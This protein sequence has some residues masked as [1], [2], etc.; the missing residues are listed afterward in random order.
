[1]SSEEKKQLVRSFFEEVWNKANYDYLDEIYTPDFVLHALWQNLSRGGAGEASGTEAAKAV[2]AGWKEGFPDLH[3]TIEEQLC[4]G[5][6]VVTRH[7]SHATHD[8]D[9]RG[10]PAT[11][12]HADMSGITVSRIEGDKIAE[13]WTMWDI[14]G[15]M[16]Q[17]GI[18]PGPGGPP[19]PPT[20]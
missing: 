7:M 4:E 2:I 13:A 5:D 19:G 18:A 11:H 8:H 10:L 16:Q 17:L 20:S 1:M 6:H 12:R 9:F 3:I 14:L 15:M